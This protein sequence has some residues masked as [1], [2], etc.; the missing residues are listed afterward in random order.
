MLPE[1]LLLHGH[2][3]VQKRTEAWL[4]LANT[5]RSS[6]QANVIFYYISFT[7][8][9]VYQVLNQVNKF[10]NQLDSYVYLDLFEHGVL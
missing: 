5:C 7:R 2:P 3:T 4:P 1:E 6:A 10:N 8:R 9:S